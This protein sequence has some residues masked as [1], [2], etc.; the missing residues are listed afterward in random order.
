LQ[1]QK[2]SRHCVW[3]HLKGRTYRGA[4]SFKGSRYLIIVIL[5]PKFAVLKTCFK[6]K[7]MK[8]AETTSK[9]KKRAEP[10]Q[11]YKIGGEGEMREV[12]WLIEQ[13]D[14]KDIDEYIYKTSLFL[15]PASFYCNPANNFICRVNNPASI[16]A[17][18]NKLYFCFK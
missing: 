5:T 17:H 3:E 14:F 4:G 16:F 1:I 15:K 11:L 8:K 7:R 2:L 18:G 9:A 13:G 10:A 6:A 12:E